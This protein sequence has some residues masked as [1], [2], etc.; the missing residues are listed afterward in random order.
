VQ[1]GAVTPR[2][3][4][5]GELLATLLSAPAFEALRT[6]EQLGYLVHSGTSDVAGAAVTLHVCVQSSIASVGHLQVP[7]YLGFSRTCI[8][9]PRTPCRSVSTPSCPPPCHLS[10]A[11]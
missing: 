2:T 10:L 3:L 8:S 9:L 1:L 11:L 7:D 4:A 6:R 5:L